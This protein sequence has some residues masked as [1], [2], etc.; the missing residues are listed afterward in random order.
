[1]TIRTLILAGNPREGGHYA[2]RAGLQRWTYRV[3][4]TA[5]QIRGLPYSGLEVHI[6]PSF[7]KMPNRYSILSSLRY[8]RGVEYFYVDPD[9][10]PT[11]AELEAEKQAAELG[12]ADNATLEAAYAENADFPHAEW[13]AAQRRAK[14]EAMSDDE[15]AELLQSNPTAEDAPQIVEAIKQKAAAKPRPSTRKT[16]TA[17]TATFFGTGG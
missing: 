11:L 4:H 5:G 13:S 3:I 12:E 1:M 15:L 2:K 16:A 8:Q 9:D 10:L 17:E 14:I 7:K 6:L